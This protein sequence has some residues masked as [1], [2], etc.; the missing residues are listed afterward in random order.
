MY[1][2][3]IGR[4]PYANHRVSAKG[5]TSSTSIFVSQIKLGEIIPVSI[6]S[7]LGP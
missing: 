7:Y 5:I 6:A 3:Y 4:E 2:T 1:E